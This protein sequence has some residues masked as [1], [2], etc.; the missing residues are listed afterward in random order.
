[1]NEKRSRSWTLVT[2]ACIVFCVVAGALY[3]YW[4]QYQEANKIQ[5]SSMLSATSTRLE[6]NLLFSGREPKKHDTYEKH[7]TYGGCA[8]LSDADILKY[9]SADALRNARS[10][11]LRMKR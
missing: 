3:G 5:A 4:Y 2:A 7:E 9:F 1:M 8:A 6:D 10:H 11:R